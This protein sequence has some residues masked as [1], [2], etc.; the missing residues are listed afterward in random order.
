MDVLS[1][2]WIFLRA[3]LLSTGGLGNLPFLHRDLPALGWAGEADFV[4]ALA[5]GQVSPGPTGLWS[6]S[7]GYLTFGVP[8]ALL[9]LLA[10]SIPPVGIL[11]VSALYGRL[12]RHRVFQYFTR[13]LTLGVVGLTLGT[14]WGLANSTIADWRGVLI[15]A[16]ALAL[17]LS[18]RVPVIIVL[19][20]AA[21]AGWLFY[22]VIP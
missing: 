20:A 8:G 22:P 21:L 6:I 7:L 10:I 4:T 3:S 9:A 11:L 18:K 19:A 17:A 12:E 16:G 15:A 1:Y 2:F 14:A 13:G 5:V